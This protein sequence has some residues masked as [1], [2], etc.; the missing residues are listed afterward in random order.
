MKRP[1]KLSSG[2]KVSHTSTPSKDLISIH[3]PTVTTDS[4]E[5][6]TD[7]IAHICTPCGYRS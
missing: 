5:N 2:E 6:I 7:V 3:A 4:N 1:K